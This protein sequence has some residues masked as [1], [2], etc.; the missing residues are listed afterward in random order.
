MR[1]ENF[2]R[3]FINRW[4]LIFLLAFFYGNSLWSS[5]DKNRFTINSND[6]IYSLQRLMVAK[7]TDSWF[8]VIPANSQ[9]RGFK[10]RTS[11]YS[12]YPGEEFGIGLRFV[13]QE[14]NVK[15]QFILVVPSMPENFPCSECKPGE[16]LILDD[17]HTIVVD[18]NIDQSIGHTGFYWGIDENDPK[19]L[20]KMSV[21][22]D[23][24]LVGSYDFLVN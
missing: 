7:V 16:I 4:V 19:G 18:K 3:K 21:I 13:P 9:H 6:F 12:V 22:V 2:K 24:L 15:V 8:F 11:R 1:I 14:A 20:Y 10:N 17:G 23:G 5:T